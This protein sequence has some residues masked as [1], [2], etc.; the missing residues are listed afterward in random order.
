[1]GPPSVSSISHRS[2]CLCFTI[3]RFVWCVIECGGSRDNTQF[4]QNCGDRT[5]STQSLWL[6]SLGCFSRDNHFLNDNYEL[7]IH[8]LHYVIVPV[9][10]VVKPRVDTVLARHLVLGPIRRVATVAS[11]FLT[12]EAGSPCNLIESATIMHPG[13][14]LCVSSIVF[15]TSPFCFAGG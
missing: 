9:S 5:Q 2:R 8:T 14:Y 10:F 13:T 12:H 11:S 4:P 15:F 3:A 6:S 7:L 1:M